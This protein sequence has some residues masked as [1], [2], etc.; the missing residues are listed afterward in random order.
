L[1][2]LCEGHHLAVHRGTLIIRGAAPDVTFE[3]ATLEEAASSFAIESRA[4]ETQRA[5]EQLGFKRHEAAAAVRA[6]RTHVGT[7]D[8]PIDVWLK[9]ALEQCRGQA[10]R[11]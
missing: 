1:L 7:T 10:T 5:L 8:Q 3:F 4:V 6:A 2:T 9:A 11:A